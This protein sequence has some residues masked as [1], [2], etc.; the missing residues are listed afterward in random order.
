MKNK[1]IYYSN[2]N[3]IKPK[4]GYELVKATVYNIKD[5]DERFGVVPFKIIEEANLNDQ[6]KF[7]F[8]EDNKENFLNIDK[9]GNEYQ[10]NKLYTLDLVLEAYQELIYDGNLKPEEINK[11]NLQEYYNKTRVKQKIKS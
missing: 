4:M 6:F 9:V 2:I 1:P 5:F 7:Y 10:S 3:Y 11:D 8:Y